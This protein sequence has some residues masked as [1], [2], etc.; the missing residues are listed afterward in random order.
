[1]KVLYNSVNATV[2]FDRADGS[3]ARLGPRNTADD[4]VVIEDHEVDL[5]GVAGLLRSR[6][7][8]LL[9]LEQSR[10]FE[11][12]RGRKAPEAPDEK[13]EAKAKAKAEKEAKAK[14]EA[15]AKAEEEAKAKAEADA[16]AEEEA[17]AKAAAE[18]DD[19]SSSKST[20]GRKKK[21]SRG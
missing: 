20:K 21:K 7:A 9:T 15:D 6:K 16:K 11:D 3:R 12:Q 18:D 14:A 13:A 1:M 17:K 19:D 8:K 10:A 4:H 2:G 5:P